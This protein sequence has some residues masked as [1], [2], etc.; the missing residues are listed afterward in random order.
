MKLGPEYTDVE[1]PLVDQ[2]V[3]MGW[4]YTL[5]DLADPARTYRDSFHETLLIKDLR[6]ALRTLNLKDGRPWL[7]PPR[8]KCDTSLRGHRRWDFDRG[9]RHRRPPRRQAAH[10]PALDRHIAKRSKA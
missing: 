10:R 9:C 2:L 6:T 1:K 5:G 3:G 8:A 7:D 4:V